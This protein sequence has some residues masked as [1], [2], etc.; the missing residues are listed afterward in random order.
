MILQEVR[1]WTEGQN[2]LSGYEFYTDIDL[3]RDFAC[4]VRESLVKRHTLVVLF[5]TIWGFCS[6]SLSWRCFTGWLL[7]DA[8]EDGSCC[9]QFSSTSSHFQNCVWMWSECKFGVQVWKGCLH[10]VFIQM[11]MV[12]HLVDVKLEQSG[13]I[14]FVYELCALLTLLFSPTR[15]M[16]SWCFWTV[17]FSWIS[18]LSTSDHAWFW[19]F[20]S[21]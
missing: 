21:W 3:A 4:D 19:P 5:G 12:H 6:S 20:V 14:P 13:C 2:V 17:S 7:V 9:H 15:G 8:E 11:Q 18:Y 16:G 1:N 10:P